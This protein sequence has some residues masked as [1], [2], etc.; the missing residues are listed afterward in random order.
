MVSLMPTS[1]NTLDVFSC[2]VWIK[3]RYLCSILLI[4]SISG[5]VCPCKLS[6]YVVGCFLFIL[7]FFIIYFINMDTQKNRIKT[8]FLGL[9]VSWYRLK[10]YF[11]HRIT[12]ITCFCEL[13]HITKSL[14]VLPEEQSKSKALDKSIWLIRGWVCLHKLGMHEIRYENW[15]N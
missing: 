5:E 3:T 9:F 6:S 12:L 4:L 8:I 13:N 15:V 14:V 2:F 1:E 10:I 7:M 11:D